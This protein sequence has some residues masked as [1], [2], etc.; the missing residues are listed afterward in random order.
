[1]GTNIITGFSNDLNILNVET[2]KSTENNGEFAKTL[3]ETVKSVNVVDELSTAGETKIDVKDEFENNSSKVSEKISKNNENSD[4]KEVESVE[5]AETKEID[6][7]ELK[8][9][10]ET[11]VTAY[12][13][14]VTSYETLVTAYADALEI[15]EDVVKQI[16]EENNISASDL[17]DS[18]NVQNI[19]MLL[20][21]IE[22]ATEILTD[23][24]LYDS[25]VEL[26]KETKDVVND[27]F[28]DSFDNF[29]PLKADDKINDLIKNVQT[30]SKDDK[31]PEN[32]FETMQMKS[33]TYVE[34]TSSESFD[35]NQVS[36]TPNAQE[37]YDQIGEY[38][39][40]L[41]TESLKEVELQLQP[42]TLGTV[43]IKVSQ[44]EGVMTAEMFTSNDTA[45]AAL[46]SQLIQLKED[47][48]NA[49]LKVETIEVKVSTNAFNENAEEDSRNE[50]NEEAERLSNQTRRITISD[51]G[52]LEEIDEMEDDEKIATEM[53][54]ANGNS[55]D[56]KA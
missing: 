20:E 51:L 19:V 6:E 36:Y 2:G 44:R 42:E 24:E 12:E 33:E 53:M 22:N 18:S 3:S 4:A 7:D 46:E 21:G 25:I 17:L 49:G 8:E 47:F 9:A 41:N 29:E 50:A 30:E 52:D 40:T 23:P 1:M 11:L 28:N 34:N 5:K 13:T 43:Q 55:L 54:T 31:E 56:Y 37:I 10:Y 16:L 48:E 14:L 45:R 38:I 27:L 32:N 26:E 15:P 39:K 35:T